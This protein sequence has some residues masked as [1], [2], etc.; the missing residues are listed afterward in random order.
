MQISGAV[1]TDIDLIAAQLIVAWLAALCAQR[2]VDHDGIVAALC[3]NVSID[4][5]PVDMVAVADDFAIGVAA[6][7]RGANQVRRA[8][9]QPVHSVKD[10]RHG[11]CA[12]GDA[13]QRVFIGR[14]GMTDRNTDAM[15]G[16]VAC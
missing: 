8:V 4:R 5:C 7:H 6:A 10:M 2:V 9:M 3:G 14:A 1:F 15:A 11:V 12:V 16:G 13:H